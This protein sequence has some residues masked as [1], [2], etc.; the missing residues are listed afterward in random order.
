MRSFCLTTFLVLAVAYSP[1]AAAAADPLPIN[2]MPAV[3]GSAPNNHASTPS[4]PAFGLL[5]RPGHGTQ[6]SAGLEAGH[7]ARIT[8]GMTGGQLEDPRGIRAG[9]AP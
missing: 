6:V 8:G 5:P 3:P 2:P 1:A 7:T 4:Q 9:D